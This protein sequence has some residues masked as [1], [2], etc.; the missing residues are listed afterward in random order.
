MAL[1]EF[2][3]WSPGNVSDLYV[4]IT[5]RL[6]RIPGSRHILSGVW[7]NTENSLLNWVI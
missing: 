3:D 5:L 7:T 6:N 4:N 1:V 2:A